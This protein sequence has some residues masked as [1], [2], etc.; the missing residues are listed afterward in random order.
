MAFALVDYLIVIIYL[1]FVSWLGYFFGRKQKTTEDYFLGSRKIPWA[2]SGISVI[3]TETSALTFIGVPAIAYS[4]NMTFIQLSIGYL[5][6]RIILSFT[7]IRKYYEEQVFTVYSYLNNRFGERIKNIVSIL[8]FITIVLANG[9]RLY[10]AALVLTVITGIP[11][12][13]TIIV[14]GIIAIIY[15][16]LGGISAV[17]WSDVIQMGILIGGGVIALFFLTDK[18]GTIGEIYSS[19]LEFGKLKLIDVSVDLSKNYT[20]W[21]GIF[22]GIFIGMAS[23]G[24]DQGMV[25]RLLTLKNEKESAKALIS[26]GIFVGP[27]FFLFLLI[28]GLLFL[29]YQK[30]PDVNLPQNPDQIF[31]YFIITVIPKGLSGLIIAGLFAA[32]MSTIDSAL[33]ALA[34]TTIVD[35][36]LPYFSKNK[37]LNIFRISK[38]FTIIWGIILVGIAFLTLFTKDWGS[39]LEIGLKVASF[40]WGGILGVFLLGYLTKRGNEQGAKTGVFIGIGTVIILSVFTSL[41]WPWYPVVGTVVTFVTGYL[42]SI[43]ISE[44]TK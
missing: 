29:F 27:Q 34:S 23:H 15:T 4:G 28:G 25:Q 40:T 20:I 11:I 24:T 38:Y 35:F 14:I 42:L 17:I 16:M 12:S 9:V 21:T 44:R 3:A 2:A 19:L 26:S 37:N 10:A 8:F 41:A 6:A 22:G 1:V 39:V 5:I 43:I 7:L 33:S 31:P 18:I 30:F 13:W 32:A 36:Y